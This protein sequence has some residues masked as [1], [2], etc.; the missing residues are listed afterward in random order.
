MF[1]DQMTALDQLKDVVKEVE[2]AGAGCLIDIVLNHCAPNCIM[3]ERNTEFGY[4][5]NNSPY[6]NVVFELD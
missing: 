4:T 5:L 3:L 6:L 2:K 1:P